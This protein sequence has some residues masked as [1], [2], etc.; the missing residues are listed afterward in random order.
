M[1][2]ALGAILGERPGTRRRA[3]PQARAA[4]RRR[5]PL[6]G[7]AFVYNRAFRRLRDES[8]DPRFL[9][10]LDG[11]HPDS[12]YRD[13]WSHAVAADD[14]DRAIYGDITTYLPDQLLAK[15]DVSAMAHSLE[16]RS[17]FLGRE[18]LEYAATLPTSLRLKGWTT[19]T[20][21]A[22]RRT[23]RAAR[24]AA[25]AQARLRDAR[26]N[27]LRGDLARRAR[28]ARLGALPRSRLA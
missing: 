26:L 4:R 19:N 24:G 18:V 14:V 20:A 12:L 1:R 5:R 27:W 15:A 22:R 9:A 8:Y 17:P 2:R 6:G 25:P 16:T 3:A 11:W 21:P 7:D 13:A 23:L 28:H 10:A